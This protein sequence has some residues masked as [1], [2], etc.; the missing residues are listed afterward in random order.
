M[1]D[2]VTQLDAQHLVGGDGQHLDGSRDQA[3]E[4]D[5]RPVLDHA[6][7]L[8]QRRHR[9][10]RAHVD[11]EGRRQLALLGQVSAV[12]TTGHVHRRLGLGA[13]QVL[14]EEIEGGQRQRA[15]S[16]PGIAHAHMG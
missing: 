7:V 5:R 14:V 10:R 15:V 11:L 4:A 3:G 16:Q 13:R 9:V 6:L 8:A 2:A 1:V 12:E